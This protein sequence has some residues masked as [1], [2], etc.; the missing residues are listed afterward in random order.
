MEIVENLREDDEPWNVECFFFPGLQFWSPNQAGIVEVHQS[1]LH[2]TRRSWRFSHHSVEIVFMCFWIYVVC[3]C[4]CFRLFILNPSCWKPHVYV[5]VW[6]FCCWNS[7]LIRPISTG[8]KIYIY[9]IPHMYQLTP[10]TAQMQGTMP[11]DM[12]V[13]GMDTIRGWKM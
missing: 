9:I 6:A 11:W 3:V 13:L 7:N 4:V 10:N 1:Q 8:E 5:V 12:R 2:H